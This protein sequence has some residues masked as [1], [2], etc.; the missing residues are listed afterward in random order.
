MISRTS[1]FDFCSSPAFTKSTQSKAYTELTQILYKAY[2]NVIQSLHKASTK[3]T[4]SLHK[5]YTKLIH[6]LYK[7][8]SKLMQSLYTPFAELIQNVYTAYTKLTQSLHNNL[9]FLRSLQSDE[10]W[11]A[12]PFVIICFCFWLLGSHGLYKNSV[13]LALSQVMNSD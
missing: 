1:Y 8:F 4:Q 12:E 11:L 5:A 7:A 3:S 10:S 9:S 13:F 2:A 6:G